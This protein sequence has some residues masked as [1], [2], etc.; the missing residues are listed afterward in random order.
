M[1]NVAPR[2]GVDLRE[3]NEVR[4][5]LACHERE[6]DRTRSARQ[7]VRVVWLMAEEIGVLAIAYKKLEAALHHS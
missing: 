3:M 7:R 1:L 6:Y 5:Q 4:R 2:A